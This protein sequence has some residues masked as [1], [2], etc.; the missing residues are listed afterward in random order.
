MMGINP[1][2]IPTY[3]RGNPSKELRFLYSL[4]Q[5]RS[6]TKRM[7]LV[8][9]GK[10]AA[11]KTTLIKRI[12]GKRDWAGNTFKT[13]DLDS[14]NTT[15]SGSEAQR[16]RKAATDGIDIHCWKPP[17]SDVALSI[18]DFAGQQLYYATHQYFLSENAMYCVVFD[19][20]RPLYHSMVHSR[21]SSSREY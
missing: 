3:Y 17:N 1:Q 21:S 20:S 10:E 14:D 6:E 4:T 12:I 13:T 16:K 5:G 7:R 8:F 19:A 9:V 18:W 2:A 11:G 15:A